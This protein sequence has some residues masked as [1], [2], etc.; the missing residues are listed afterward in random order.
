MLGGAVA[1]GGGTLACHALNPVEEGSTA[2]KASVF[3][4]AIRWAVATAVHGNIRR[5]DDLEPFAMGICLRRRYF[6]HAT[7]KVIGFEPSF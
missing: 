7:C 6:I 4:S 2:L 3:L 5:V 1:G